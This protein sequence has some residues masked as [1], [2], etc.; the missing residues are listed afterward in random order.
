[1][2]TTISNP[3]RR[4]RTGLA[5]LGLA[6]ATGALIPIAAQASSTANGCLQ[7]SRSVSVETV[8]EG[9]VFRL[10]CAFFLRQPEPAGFNYWVESGKSVSEMANYFAQSPEFNV[11]YGEL[12]DSEFISLIYRN[13]LNRGQDL[14]GYNFWVSKLESNE[15]NRGQVMTFFSDSPEYRLYIDRASLI[16]PASTTTVAVT[17]TVTASPPAPT[18]TSAPPISSSTTSVLEVPCLGVFSFIEDVGATVVLE[19]DDC[20]EPLHSWF[21]HDIENEGWWAWDNDWHH[22]GPPTHAG[23]FEL[24]WFLEGGSERRI[25]ARVQSQ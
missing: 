16:N 19:G 6:L 7:A 4:W 3:S 25:P 22:N 8:R 13:V 14:E 12:D 23:V 20:P 5:L 17:T 1:M 24:V 9:S 10:Y 11:L 21:L 18:V 2:E 15:L